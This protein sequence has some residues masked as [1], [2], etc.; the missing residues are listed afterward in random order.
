MYSS[1]GIT[2]WP[3]H[4]LDHECGQNILQK[5]FWSALAD[6]YGIV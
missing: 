4:S 5:L 6:I 2:S 1:P 3:L